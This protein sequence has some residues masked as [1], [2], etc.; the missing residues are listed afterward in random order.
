MKLRNKYIL[1]VIIVH[2]IFV[3]LSTLLFNESR[4]YFIAAEV[5][6]ALSIVYAAHIYKTLLKPLN[7]IS[8]G[9]DVIREK[10]FNTKF[11]ETGQDD[12]NQLIV[13]YNAMIDELRNERVKQQEQHYF[14]ERL[15]GA[16]P[17]GII[18]LD[19]DNKIEIMN[20][21]AVKILGGNGHIPDG[22]P[23]GELTKSPGPELAL[24]SDGETRIIKINGIQTYKCSR[25]H[26]LDR[27]FRRHFI[28]IEEF[29]KE[30][31]TSQ[32]R[33]YEKVIR[34]MS[35]EINNSVGAINSILNSSL[36]YKDQLTP[37]DRK[38][39]D[40]AIRVAIDRNHGLNRFMANFA[41]VVRIPPPTKEFYD[42]HDL[43]RSVRVLMKS[44][45]QKRNIEWV[46]NL[47]RHPCIVQ[48]DSRQIEQ[49][50]VNIFKNA[51]EAIGDNGSIVV[52]TETDKVKL[53]KIT[54]DGCGISPQSQPH[55]FNPFYSSKRYGQ[56]IG[57]TMTRD[58]LANHGFRFNLEMNDIG[59]TEFSI[60][61]KSD[62]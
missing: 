21:A 15:I 10:D 41:D 13:V 14:L 27:G 32:K 19:L 48:I 39:F 50:L 1:F 28:L 11:V 52:S 31:I 47:D 30:I 29:T 59:L 12:I 60:N 42:I 17:L 23:L 18:I 45:C 46:W 8:T 44:E 40:D 22:S 6:I 49:V 5:L 7:L 38:D 9:I 62:G 51:M 57:L 53:L 3:A 34:M 43:L 26:F 36:N 16:T 61:F 25:S 33:A 4:Y 35:H 58:I 20:P 24:L 37:E 56:G 2:S 54:D 55:L